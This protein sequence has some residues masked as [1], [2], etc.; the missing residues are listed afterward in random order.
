MQPY[1]CESKVE[2]VEGVT[3]ETH[4]EPGFE[5]LV[6]VVNSNINQISEYVLKSCD[7]KDL[8]GLPQCKIESPVFIRRGVELKN[9]KELVYELNN[10][11][12]AM[13]FRNLLSVTYNQAT[14][15]YR[16]ISSE[17]NNLASQP[18]IQGPFFFTQIPGDL[19]GK[20]EILH[21][22]IEKVYEND[23]SQITATLPESI[24]KVIYVKSFFNTSV[25]FNE[26][27]VFY[28]NTNTIQVN[29]KNSNKIVISQYGRVI[30]LISENGSIF[31]FKTEDVIAVEAGLNGF[32]DTCEVR[33][34][35]YCLD[36]VRLIFKNVLTNKVAIN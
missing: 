24:H 1:L 11:T 6:K 32:E 17:L 4:S 36:Q 9:S 3:L 35:Y 21:Y 34:A 20:V 18:V 2:D 28:L 8:E 22:C 12:Q 10:L 25:D 26:A 7:K 33:D 23:K 5:S 30:T 19:Y 27:L 16:Y 29:F 13:L 15:K 31:N 14:M